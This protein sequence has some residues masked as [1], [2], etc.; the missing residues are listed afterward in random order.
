M[1]KNN[2]QNKQRK[3][4]VCTNFKMLFNSALSASIYFGV[5]DCNISQCCSGKRQSAGK[6]NGEKL[7]W[8][9]S[10]DVDNLEE[11]ISISDDECKKKSLER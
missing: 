8:K 9:Y 7:I 10:N 2:K 4:V 11:Y 6:Y 5:S 3:S 1:E